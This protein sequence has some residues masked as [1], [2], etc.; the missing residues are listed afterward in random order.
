MNENM[1]AHAEAISLAKLF[2][3]AAKGEEKRTLA[4]TNAL[5]NQYLAQP[6]HLDIKT[7]L[8][9]ACEAAD[10]VPNFTSRKTGCN[11]GLV[12]P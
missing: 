2:G 7:L 1:I 3:R 10:Y 4:T 5:L 12:S 8:K 11:T 9:V 6:D